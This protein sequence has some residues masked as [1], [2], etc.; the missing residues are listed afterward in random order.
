[1]EHDMKTHILR[2]VICPT[3]TAESGRS[4]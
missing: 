2:P 3:K 4:G 1:M